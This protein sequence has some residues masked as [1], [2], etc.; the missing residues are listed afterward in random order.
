M[1]PIKLTMSAFANYANEQVLDFNELQGRSMFLVTGKTGAGKTTIFDAISYA[2]FGEPSGDFR[3]VDSLRSDYADGNTET[4]VEFEFELRGEVYKIRRRPSQELNKQRGEGTRTFEAAAELHIPNVERP[5]TGV[6][7]VNKRVIEVIGVTSDQ[8]RQIVMLPQGQFINFLKASSS[9]KEKI[10]REIFGTSMFNE[11]Q[12]RLTMKAKELADELKMAI[13]ERDVFI[14]KIKCEDESILAFKIREENIDIQTV[15][16]LT[17][18]LTDTD[19]KRAIEYETEI[20]DLR[21]LI[22][23]LENKKNNLM[24]NRECIEIY[25]RTSDAY[26]EKQRGI[27]DINEKKERLQKGRRAFIVKIEEDKVN[28]EKENKTLI[29][30]RIL[31]LKSEISNDKIKI[32]EA[33]QDLNS[34]KERLV[35]KDK[36]SIEVNKLEEQREKISSYENKKKEFSNLQKEFKFI[37]AEV[38]RLEQIEKQEEDKKE[39]LELYINEASKYIDKVNE[40]KILGIEQKAILEKV[41]EL[42]GNLENIRYKE[43]EHQ[44][45]KADYEKVEKKFQESK[46]NFEK[47]D[48]LFRKAQAGI[49]AEHLVAG[50]MCPV[51]GSIE[52]PMKAIKPAEVLSEDKINELKVIYEEQ[53]KKKDIELRKLEILYAEIKTDIKNLVTNKVTELLSVLGEEFLTFNDSQQRERVTFI[54]NKLNKELDDV[55][56]EYKLLYAKTKNLEIYK[57]QLEEIKKASKFIKKS[58]ESQR[59]K[60]LSIKEELVRISENIKNIEIEIP[61]DLRS[62]VLLSNKIKSIQKEIDFI[63]HEFEISEKRYKQIEILL[64]NNI[65][66]LE[67]RDK[68]L[69]DINRQIETLNSIF[70]KALNEQGFIYEEYK[71]SIKENNLEKLEAEINK[72]ET[73]FNTLKGAYE[74][75]KADF[76]KQEINDL[77]VIKAVLEITDKEIEEKTNKELEIQN[78]YKGIELRRVNNEECVKDIEKI[79]VKIGDKE[80]EYTDV[81]HLAGIAKG[82]GGNSKKMTFESYILTS[83]FEEIIKVANQRLGKMTSGRFELRRTENIKGGGTKGLDLSVLDNNTGFVRGINSLSGGESFKAALAIALGLADV[84][85]SNAGGVSIETMFIDEGFGTLDPDSLDSAIQCLLDL[86]SGGRLVGVISH[87]QELKERIDARL[88]VTMKPNNRGSVAKFIIG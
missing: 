82:R 83:Y 35:L 88:E 51:C 14:K 20:N 3:S 67:L 36:Y 63:N 54:G 15:L 24:R 31:E 53:S 68:S 18:E 76:E 72:F 49:L 55:R 5:V 64:N 41:K 37:E 75:V 28:N 65:K 12:D 38:K 25:K 43:M 52:H 46:F 1:R 71:M 4:Y 17:K 78:I 13:K 10:F 50:E 70:E 6:T 47:A 26:E 7:N 16:E 19:K 22:K 33:E 39:K 44:K 60:Y 58:L 23:S 86:Q 69:V 29:E 32:K 79:R 56:S 42:Q 73:E 48:D 40:L 59:E 45:L 21:K 85:Q 77:D 61:E 81:E 66:E 74:Q 30:K 62:E 34:K 8:F 9:Q 11:I 2:L 27:L 84:I 87:V 80:I 57:E